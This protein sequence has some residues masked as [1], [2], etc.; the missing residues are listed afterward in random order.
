MF[1]PVSL[2]IGLRYSRSSK[3]NAFISF[4]SFFS[5]AGIAIGLMALFTV[6][7]VMNG[8][9]NNLKTNMLGLIPHIEVSAD[10]NSKETM[11]QLKQQ[12][13][14]SQDIKQV[15]LYRHGEAILQTNQDLHG[16]LLQGLYDEG[17]SLYNVKD[18]IVAGNWSQ[19]MDSNYH[20][21][22]SRYLSRKLGISL[23]DKVRVIMP[24]ASSYTPLGRVPS[25]RLFTVGALYETQ[26]EIDMSLAFTSGYSLG[27]VLKLA[28]SAAPNLSV[29]LYEP[30]AVEQVL[31]SQ[32]AILNDYTVADWRASQGTLFAAVAMEK[33]IMSML[34]G[35][36]V[37]VA[38]FNIVSA[39]TMMVSEKQSEVAILQTLGLTP[40]Q[41]QH[42]FM[43][44][45]LY[46]G[47]I[48]TSIGAL[49]GVLLSSNINELLNM[50]GINLLAGVSLPV[51]FDVM[52]L[53]LIAAG[54]IAM[55]FLATL[56]PARKAAK[57]N[58]AEVL[59]YE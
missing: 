32:S 57:V 34:L 52:S 59:R 24:N 6:S 56:Y 3:G 17:S 27:R 13:E 18:K 8:F 26:S 5:I 7:S 29:S 46:N 16:V 14:N 42:V 33:R 48:G 44:Q 41:V 10:D 4:I 35:L 37:L 51:K 21:A 28:K 49:L 58:P 38:V 50:L 25:Q 20:I 53:S 47:L 39:L 12:L 43:I 23:G 22:I 11:L 1:Q 9:E 54:S 31:Q 15:N 30:F 45:G 55:S 2:F 36:I 19:V 40:L